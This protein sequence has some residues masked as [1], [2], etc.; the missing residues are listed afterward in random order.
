ML[1]EK[2]MLSIASFKAAEMWMHAAHHLTKGPAFI[3]THEMLYGRIYETLSG[4]FDKLVEKMIYTFNDEE[5]GCPIHL[6]RNSSHILSRYDSPANLDEKSISM[7]ALVLL[8][9]HMKG[10]EILLETLRQE[11]LASLGIEDFLSAAYNQ[12]ESYAYMLNQHIKI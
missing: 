3:S 4:D 2:I 5:M 12:Y 8:V 10:V 6:S 1:K 11:N 9:D 7:L